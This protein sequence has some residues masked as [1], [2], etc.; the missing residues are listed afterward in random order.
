MCAARALDHY[1]D[2]ARKRQSQAG[3]NKSDPALVTNLSEA[4]KGRARDKAGADFN[5]GGMTIQRA[6][7]FLS[8]IRP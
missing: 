8:T 7:W 5:V 6:R 4:D 2:E 3:G 1:A